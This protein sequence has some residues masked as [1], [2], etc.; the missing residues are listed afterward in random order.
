MGFS[1]SV[2]FENVA[3]SVSLL[4]VSVLMLWLSRFIAAAHAESSALFWLLTSSSGVVAVSRIRGVCVGC[5]LKEGRVVCIVVQER[6]AVSVKESVFL[7]C[8][9]SFL[10]I[11]L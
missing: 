5:C 4:M 6:S 9:N 7:R 2:V 8:T 11:F 10:V 1:S 3:S